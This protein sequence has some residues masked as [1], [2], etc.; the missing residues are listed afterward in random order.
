[1]PLELV[2]LINILCTCAL[3]TLCTV[4]VYG[5]LVM[6]WHRVVNRRYFQQQHAI[7]AA[8]DAKDDAALVKAE[9]YDL[10]TDRRW[11]CGLLGPKR[12]S[13]KPPKFT[14]FPKS[15][16]WPTPLFF[17]ACVFV[18]GLTRASVKL[19]CAHPDGCGVPC[20]ALPVCVLAL[21]LCLMTATVA[22]LLR[23]RRKHSSVIPWKAGGKK[24]KPN[25][26]RTQSLEPTG[27]G[28]DRFAFP[29]YYPC[30]N[31]GQV[32]C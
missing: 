19:L 29:F 4:V 27:N 31:P 25:E 13:P 11:L 15:L 7:A 17:T 22:H 5:A 1:M 28:M 6:A 14:P 32:V 23:F 21:L 3:A 20:V 12:K 8:I 16:V 10:G 24:A 26:V 9:A 18:T 2:T 30:S